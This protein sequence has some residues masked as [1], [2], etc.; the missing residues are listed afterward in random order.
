MTTLYVHVILTMSNAVS[1][2]DTDTH[3]LARHRYNRVP[4]R[5]TVTETV[6]ILKFRTDYSKSEIEGVRSDL[7]SPLFLPKS[8]IY[9]Q[10]ST[11]INALG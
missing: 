11:I 2:G 9:T 6:K 8:P 3:T 5:Y 10:R 4:I 7:H 1:P